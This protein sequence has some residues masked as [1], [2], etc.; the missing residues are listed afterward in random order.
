MALGATPVREAYQRAL[1][2]WVSGRFD[3]NAAEQAGEECRRI[4]AGLVGALPEEVALIPSVSSAAGVV[5]AQL[6]P[7]R[8]GE[9]IVVGAEEY[10]S[11]YY[12]WLL[13]RDR[14]YDVRTVSF[15][16]GPP[17]VDDYAVA[18]NA[19][20]RLLAVSAVQSSTGAPANLAALAEIVHRG[21]G[22][23][24]VDACQAAG[25]VPLDVRAAD[26]DFLATS[27]HKFLCGTRGMGYLFVRSGLVPALR[28][29]TPG[30]KA[31]RDPLRSFYGPEM[32]LSSTASKL[33]SSLAWFA[34]LGERA[35]LRIFEQLGAQ[36]IFEHNRDLVRRLRERMAGD[37]MSTRDTGGEVRSTIIS[38]P[39]KQP[40]E[41]LRRFA[42]DRIVASVRAGRVRISLHFYNSPEDIDLVA[43]LLAANERCR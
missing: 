25:A 39:V 8:M 19:Q 28:P 10:T 17:L 15:A 20:T 9:N 13:L 32:N 35:A 37:G 22:W 29:V 23:L 16:D 34:A 2:E 6:G 43:T 4:F 7:A 41:M 26:V 38:I 33:D 11:N 14:G 12:P 31:A 42:E 24:F 21:G 18:V 36:Q 30:W 3:Y 27:G 1:S 5:A 40:E